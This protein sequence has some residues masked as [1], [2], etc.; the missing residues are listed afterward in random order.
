MTSEQLL[1]AKHLDGRT[2]QEKIQLNRKYSAKLSYHR[3][4]TNEIR[5]QIAEF[6]ETNFEIVLP[7]HRATF[8][9]IA[10]K[11]E[12]HNTVIEMF[13]NLIKTYYTLANF[14]ES[15]GALFTDDKGRYETFTQAHIFSKHRLDPVWNY[16][17]SNII[18]N[19]YRNYLI[20]TKI[21]EKYNPVHITL[22]VPH[23]G[24]T[25]NGQKFYAKEL[26]NAFREVRR[27]CG[28]KSNVY[29]GEY[30]I[31]VKSSPNKENGLHIHIH[32]LAFLKPGTSI[33]N[34]IKWLSDKWLF[35]T[36]ASQ[37]HVEKIYFYEKGENGKYITELKQNNR[38]L[39][40]FEQPDGTYTSEANF[41]EVRKKIYVDKF[42]REVMSD[43]SLSSDEKEKKILN[44]YLYGI[45]ETIKY[46]FKTESLTLDG[47]NYDLPLIEE[48]LSNTKGKRLYS[49]FGE[50]YNV[51]ELS[52]NRLD[53]SST[54]EEEIT[55]EANEEVINPFTGELEPIEKLV[56]VIFY[57]ERQKRTGKDDISPYRL[58]N[59]KQDI[60]QELA[61]GK[62]IK[63][64]L[65][66]II[67]RKFKPKKICIDD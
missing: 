24:G 55:A 5:E 45:L 22:T 23:S 15:V 17:K 46:H 10:Q 32:S 40:T 52:F 30:G 31:E 67:K 63:D 7:A 58:I 6:I 8:L 38:D 64:V 54:S 12:I 65:S 59:N 39:E 29:A 27:S 51:P 13:P 42:K 18:R 49:R 60:Y 4:K 28:W 62:P 56:T 36:D 34:F 48:V 1:K 66:E 53:D 25:W 19:I 2:N 16:R 9:K 57:P 26:L 35:L 61:R 43:I 44:A 41:I 20:D 3:H 14:G 11:S 50:F 37:I 47:R 33:K 21:Y